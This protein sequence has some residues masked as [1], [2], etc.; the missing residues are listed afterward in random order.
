MSTPEGRLVASLIRKTKTHDA[1]DDPDAQ[2]L[3]DADLAILGTAEPAYRD[4]AERI[5]QEY[6][7]VPEA[8]YC[9]GR[10]QVLENFL[11]RPKIFHFLSQLED[12]ARRNIAAEISR[13]AVA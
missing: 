7:W 12:P 1:G 10:R 9:Q 11:G 5:R 6:A 13:L 4:Y 8:D 2:V 3:L